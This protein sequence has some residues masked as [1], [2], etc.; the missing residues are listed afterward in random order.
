M[1]PKVSRENAKKK[2]IPIENLNTWN[3]P[4]DHTPFRI[5]SGSL[6]CTSQPGMTKKIPSIMNKRA[7]AAATKMWVP[8]CTRQ[9]NPGAAGGGS[10]SVCALIYYLRSFSRLASSPRDVKSAW[11]SGGMLW[12]PPTDAQEARGRCGGG[13]RGGGKIEERGPPWPR[14]HLAA[15]RALA[16]QHRSSSGESRAHTSLNVSR[17]QERR[18]CWCWT[19]AVNGSMTW[20][21]WWGR[22]SGSKSSVPCVTSEGAPKHNGAF[23]HTLGMNF[24]WTLPCLWEVHSQARGMY[25]SWKTLKIWILHNTEP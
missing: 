4:D 22:F 5:T 7:E 19:A 9:P 15:T 24:G 2:K 3:R 8:P 1:L 18:E 25:Y 16:W 23:E 11:R 17:S 13:G 12:P 10:S 20:W 6:F 14:R 21:E